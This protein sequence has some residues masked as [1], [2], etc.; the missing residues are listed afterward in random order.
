MR[1]FSTFSFHSFSFDQQT[2]IATFTYQADELFFTETV[3]FSTTVKKIR[4]SID[5]TIL[6]TLLQH[7]H[8]ALGISYYKLSPTAKILVPDRRT[9]EMLHF[10]KSFYLNG[11]GEFMVVNGLSPKDICQFSNSPLN[12]TPAPV[13]R[14][15]LQP[16]A[17]VFFGGGK[18]SLVSVELLKERHQPFFLF[19]MGNLP[20][21]ALAASKVNVP[22]IIHT[23]TLDPKLF[24]MNQS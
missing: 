8:I 21:H 5:E 11:L 24:A 19:S 2:L 18:D 17:L 23:R 16:T 1:T 22:R 15:M 20:L 10:W 7:I 4:T 6:H 14:E 3:N 12:G 13:A 9:P